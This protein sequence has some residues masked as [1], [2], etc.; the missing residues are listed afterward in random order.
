MGGTFQIR[1]I[2]YKY[3]LK[4]AFYSNQLCVF[5]GVLFVVR[6]LWCFGGALFVAAL[7]V[8]RTV[9]GRVCISKSG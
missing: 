7:G 8:P 2:K 5:C 1:G 3:N 4:S 6:W 9:D